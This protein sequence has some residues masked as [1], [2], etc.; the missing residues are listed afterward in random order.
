[1]GIQPLLGWGHHVLCRKHGKRTVISYIHIWYGR[2]LMILGIVNGGLGLQ[3]AAGPKSWIIAYS[4]VGGLVA[5]LYAAACVLKDLRGSSR[6]GEGN[7]R[8]KGHNGGG[9]NESPNT[10]PE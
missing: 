9:D 6:T 7:S 2:C 10:P 5:L 4:V 8:Q 3:L 1:M